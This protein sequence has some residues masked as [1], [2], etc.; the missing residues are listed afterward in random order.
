M[1]VFYKTSCPDR[2]DLLKVFAR[3]NRKCPTQA[4]TV[5]WEYLKGKSL[6]YRFRRQHSVLDYIADFI[7]L[8]K[9]LIIEVDGEYHFTEQQQQEDANRTERLH[10]N[11][12]RIIRF[13]NDEILNNL[14]IVIEKI[15]ERLTQ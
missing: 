1:S 9:R 15:K 2:Y 5:L 10:A 3:D 13:R 11:G 12:Y 14:D 7:C 8:E 6:G 4:E